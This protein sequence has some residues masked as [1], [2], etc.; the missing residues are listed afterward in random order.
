M[1]DKNLTLKQ[2][3]SLQNK[4]IDQILKLEDEIKELE[5]L[6]ENASTPDSIEDQLFEEEKREWKENHPT[7]TTKTLKS[8]GK[9][10]KNNKLSRAAKATKEGFKEGLE[11][12]K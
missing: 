1:K 6:K 9:W 12:A 11:A 2:I 8:V 7:R 3:E 4:K 10:F 5:A